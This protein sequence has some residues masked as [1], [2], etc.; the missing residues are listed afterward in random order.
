MEIT[1]DTGEAVLLVEGERKSAV[2]WVMLLRTMC[3]Q[4]KCSETEI[5]VVLCFHA[6]LCE[7][8]VRQ[9]CARKMRRLRK[10]L[11]FLHWEQ[12]KGKSKF[13]QKKID[14]DMINDV[15]YLYIVL[16]K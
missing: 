6:V 8:A 3:A 5:R 14:A 11:N 12:G 10:A 13:I 4:C 7:H 9:Y 1:N 16:N 15:R 2:L